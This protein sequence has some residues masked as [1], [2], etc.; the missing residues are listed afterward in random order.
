M[1]IYKQVLRALRAVARSP[2]L[3]SFR[4]VPLC[5]L[6]DLQRGENCLA[7]AP[8]TRLGPYEVLALIGRGGMGEV[9]RAEIPTGLPSLSKLFPSSSRTVRPLNG[10]SAKR[11]P[12]P[13]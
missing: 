8:S 5:K 3:S 1:L 13:A 9:Y 2:S 11:V 4:Q 12:S 10:S 6:L 7:L